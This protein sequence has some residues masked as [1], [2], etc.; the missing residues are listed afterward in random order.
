ME[1]EAFTLAQAQ[2]EVAEQAQQQRFES[3]DLAE[4]ERLQAQFLV[5]LD[6]WR[7]DVKQWDGD[8]EAF[9]SQENKLYDECA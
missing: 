5:D 1:Q 2:F 7:R 6:Q 8:F 9:R 3:R 4:F